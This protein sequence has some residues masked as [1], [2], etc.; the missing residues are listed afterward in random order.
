MSKID[1]REM[2]GGAS[3]DKF[4]HSF[5][6]VMENLQD[7]NTPYKDKREIVI[8]MAFVQNEQRDNVVAS[9]KVTEK[10]ASQ[11]ELTTQFAM[12]KDLRTGE[13]IAE[14]YGNQLK[15][16]MALDTKTANVDMETGEVLEEE[17]VV[18]F[19]KVKG[20]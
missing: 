6:R 1:L 13:V 8:K 20:E 3:Q 16:Q 19:R 14:E 17:T 5:E 7:R 2:V 11:G 10:L 12:G 4:Q 18:D 15:G 9:V